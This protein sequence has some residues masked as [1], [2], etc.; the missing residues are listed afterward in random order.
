VDTA[1]TPA[2]RLHAG[3]RDEPAFEELLSVMLYITTC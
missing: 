3:T 2:S 1:E